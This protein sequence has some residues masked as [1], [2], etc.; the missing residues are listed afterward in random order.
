MNVSAF[1][2]MTGDD[3]VCRPAYQVLE[4]WLEAMPAPLLLRRKAEAEL[5]FRRVGITFAV[6]GD[7]EGKERVIP[8]DIIPRIL[9][10]G[11]WAFL[12]R[13]LEQRVRALNLFLK[14]VYG[15]REILKAG[16]VPE[17]I[18]FRNP[19]FRPEVH[20]LSVPGDIRVHIAGI[21]IVRVGE[22]RFY[23]LED[24][25]RT[26]SGVSY[27]LEN[28][29]AML[30]LFPDL[31]AQQRI[32]PID[33]YLDDLLATLKS[34]APR[35]AGADPTL[36]VLTPGP[37][38]SAYYEHSFLAD[39]L[40]VELV[41]GRDLFVREV[42]VFMRTSEG[43]KRVDVD[44]S[45]IDDD[46]LDPLV[47]RPESVI[48]VPGLMIAYRAGNVAIANAPGTGVGDD[49]ALYSYVPEIIRFYTGQDPILGNVPTWR[50]REPDALAY[51]LENLA[52]LVV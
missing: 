4:R 50:C 8:F 15:A 35:T 30:R 28:R 7:T 38:N 18:V 39:R 3:G 14:D 9:T 34:I 26:P 1:D 31:L 42:V 12:A 43:P 36:V 33:N 19:Y 40:G 20:G 46:Y 23:V 47:F 45:R 49:K 51:V 24:N 29:E 25:L 21:D 16:V 41:E 52:E 32:A 5:L 13:G 17:D 6:Y 27:M 37:L 2:E 11:E 10:A 48:G 44:Y 22:S